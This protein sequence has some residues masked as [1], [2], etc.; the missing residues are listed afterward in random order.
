MSS[1]EFEVAL[2]PDRR[3]RCLLSMTAVLAWSCGLWLTAGL[4]ISL[5]WRVS[6]GLLWTADV[7]YGMWRLVRGQQRLERIVVS[8]GGTL[9]AVSSDGSRDSLVLLTG[10][11]VYRRIAWLRFRYSD[12]RQ[13]AELLMGNPARDHGW[14][15]LQ[16][17][18]RM[19]RDAFGH[20]VRP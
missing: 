6:G 1:R 16:L 13:H 5:P 2:E 4:D 18:W 7:G 15:G 17:I 10:S 11:V 20:P 12:G 19:S 14:H 3:L 8:S 9:A